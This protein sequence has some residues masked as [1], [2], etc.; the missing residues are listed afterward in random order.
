MIIRLPFKWQ[1]AE[2]GRE[3]EREK[4]LID[5]CVTCWLVS[6]RRIS[7]AVVVVGKPEK[8]KREIL[9]AKIRCIL[10]MKQ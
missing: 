2:G 6:K 9:F 4:A 7:A 5:C 1:V 8:E 3:R 10:Q